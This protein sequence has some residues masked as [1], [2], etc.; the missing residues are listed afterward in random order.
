MAHPSGFDAMG[1]PV[2]PERISEA[3]RHAKDMGLNTEDA[4]TIVGYM[5]DAL[6]RD[7]PH[8]ALRSSSVGFKAEK[9]PAPLDLTGRYRLLAVLCTD[10][11]KR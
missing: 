3:Y 4:F 6:E 9:Q 1:L 7:D 8:R 5:A 10:P 11:P 2:P